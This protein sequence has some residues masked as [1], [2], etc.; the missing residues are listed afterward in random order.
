MAGRSIP[1]RVFSTTLAMA[2]RAPVLP[3]DTTPAASPSWT[4]SMARRRL[5]RRPL[6]SAKEG[7]SFPETATS[8]W[9]TVHT[10]ASF[11]IPRSNG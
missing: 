4:A 5:Y 6:R 9:W 10:R 11:S 7:L 1:G 2:M 8:V 3:A